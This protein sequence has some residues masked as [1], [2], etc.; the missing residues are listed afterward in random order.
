M[1]KAVIR[2]DSGGKFGLGHIMR[3]KALADAL[4]DINIECTFAVYKIHSDD[5]VNPHQLIFIHTEEFLSLAQ[6]YDVIIIDHYD[7][8]SELFF[9][10]A[11]Y[12]Q[13]ILIVLDD[14]CNRG[15][16]YADVI[17]NPVQQALSLP[18]KE[19]SPKAE[20][21]IGSDYLLL[22]ESFQKIQ[23]APF[24]QKDTVLIQSDWMRI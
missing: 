4:N 13:A 16:L 23:L 19:V 1:K 20:L 11:N 2:L 10:L 5:A 15:Q 14:E 6:S 9:Q 18:Y 7:Y 3:S 8:T 17:I 24:G 22:R 12:Q 21:L